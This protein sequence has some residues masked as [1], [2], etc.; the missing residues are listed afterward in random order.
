[1]TEA[2]GTA[3]D[4]KITAIS[5]HLRALGEGQTYKATLPHISRALVPKYLKSQVN[6]LNE[7]R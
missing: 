3:R 1:M 7:E 2:L 5:H 4:A 6:L